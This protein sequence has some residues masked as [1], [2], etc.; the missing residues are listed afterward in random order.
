VRYVARR[1]ASR[2][3]STRARRGATRSRSARASSRSRRSAAR[4][5]SRSAWSGTSL[6]RWYSGTS[7]PS[8]SNAGTVP[9]DPAVSRAR[10]SETGPT[11][12]V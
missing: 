9:L 12:S 10:P 2:I 11:L 1:S 4:R 6:L 8:P 5:R 7:R 3:R